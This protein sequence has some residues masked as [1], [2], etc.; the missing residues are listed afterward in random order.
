[1]RVQ[2][3][4]K[5][6]VGVYADWW[7]QGGSRGRL[8]RCQR[9]VQIAQVLLCAGVVIAAVMQVLGAMEVRRY[10]RGLRRRQMNSSPA[11]W[12]DGYGDVELP[13]EVVEAGDESN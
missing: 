3:D 2:E 7:V 9:V 11:G 6:R 4:V 13:S 8:A 1:M 10:E 12:D 5:S